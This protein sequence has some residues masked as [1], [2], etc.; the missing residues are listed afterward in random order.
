M[1]Y[2]LSMF[3]RK[4]SQK[5]GFVR[6]WHNIGMISLLNPDWL[7]SLLMSNFIQQGLAAYMTG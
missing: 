7:L 4:I 5:E 6:F 3:Y 1:Q 2:T